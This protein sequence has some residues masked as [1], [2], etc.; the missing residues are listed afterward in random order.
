MAMTGMTARPIQPIPICVALQTAIWLLYRVLY[1][2]LAGSSVCHFAHA[3]PTMSS[4]SLPFLF[5]F[6]C[7]ATSNA[8]RI[9]VL[10][11]RMQVLKLNTKKVFL[12]LKKGKIIGV[13]LIELWGK[14]KEFKNRI[15]GKTGGIMC[16]SL[17]DDDQTRGRRAF[18][19]SAR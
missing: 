12:P 3:R 6:T 11:F 2:L 13:V 8:L 5:F 7:L 1:S 18:P 14:T 16:S 15:L 19:V 9:G 4:I 17:Y 10:V